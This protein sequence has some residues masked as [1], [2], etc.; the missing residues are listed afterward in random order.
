VF[1]NF[2]EHAQVVPSAALCEMH[3]P[4]VMTDLVS[5]GDMLTQT[6]IALQPYQFVWLTY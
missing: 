4:E 3:L 6:D 2:S 1:A 5:G